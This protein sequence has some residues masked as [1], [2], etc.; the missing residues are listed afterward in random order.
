M[1]KTIYIAWSGAGA[2][3]GSSPSNAYPYTFLGNQAN[4]GGG[5]LQLNPGDTGVLCGFIG[6][7]IN[8]VSGGTPTNPVTILFQTGAR[9]ST[10]AFTTMSIPFTNNLVIDGG[11]NG[12]MENTNNGSNF[13]FQND[14]AGILCQGVGNLE[15]KNLTFQNFYVHNNPNDSADIFVTAGVYNN[16]N[17]NNISIHDCKFSNMHWCIYMAPGAQFNTVSGVYIYN[18]T[19]SD[20]DHGIAG[21]GGVNLNINNNIFGST[22]IW[23]CTGGTFHHDGIHMFWGSGGTSS[24]LNIYNN[25]FTGYWGVDNTAHIFLEGDFTHNNPNSFIN[26][27]IYNNVFI[28]YSG[29]YLNNGFMSVGGINCSVLSN[30][31]IGA[32]PTGVY[33][34]LG[35]G[36]GGTGTSVKNN[37]VAN[38]STFIGSSATTVFVTGGLNGNIYYN[39]TAGGNSPFFYTGVGYN[40]F[41]LWQ[42]ATTQDQ[43]SEMITGVNINLMNQLNGTLIAGSLA[44]GSG[45]NL[46]SIFTTDFA[47]NPR[48]SSGPWDIGA[49]QFLVYRLKRLGAHLKMYGYT[50]N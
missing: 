47:G 36:I 34:S 28:Q 1:G 50:T 27:K 35:M 11:L 15:V 33:N 14:T 48:P 25:L 42:T 32:Y 9:I 6:T 19:F 23:D 16:G 45:T 41:A 31:F 7:G 18:N 8:V 30:T 24:G 17:G 2:I 13:S 20:Y 49:Y 12:I 38:V 44:I 21:L 10:P 40:T 39:Q 26:T 46:S 4:W 5:A 3:D 22:S 43:N 37:I 29:N